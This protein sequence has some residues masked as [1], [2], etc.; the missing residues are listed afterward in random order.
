MDDQIVGP[1]H[2]IDPERWVEEHGDCL[3]RYALLRTRDSGVAEDLVQETFL[4]GL[5]SRESFAGQSSERTWLVGIL[6][7]KIIDHLRRVCRERDHGGEESMPRELEEQFDE[8][9]HWRVRDG[10]GPKEWRVDAQALF[11]RKEFWAV[12]DRCLS[13][14]PERTAHAFMLREMEEVETGEV[15][16]VLNIT[17]TNLWVMLHRARMQL[18]RC[19]EINWFG[20]RRD[21]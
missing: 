21:G 3:Y 15:C 4:A 1:A 12:L 11:E 10:F 2:A 8:A 9:Q 5:K 14:L 17:A 13:G 18:R 7:H 19:I 6:K 16:K 20:S